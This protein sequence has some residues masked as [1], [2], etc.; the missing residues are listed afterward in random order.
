VTFDID[1][2]GILSVAAKDLGTGRS[3]DV[4]IEVSSGLSDADVD[5]MRREAEEH[6]DEDRKRREGVDL[7]NQAESLVHQV[8]RTLEKHADKVPAGDKEKVE[9]AIGKVEEARKGEDIAAIKKAM[10]EL[11]K[12]SHKVAEILYQEEAA[13]AAKA[14]AAGAAAP[15]PESPGKAK[16]GEDIKDADFEVKD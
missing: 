1:A 6:A 4:K 16:G 8:R 9:A 3:K 10:E 7:Q 13:K 2:N 12:A 15:G 14:G 5:R 11:T